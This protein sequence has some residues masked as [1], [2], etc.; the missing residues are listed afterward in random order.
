M[1]LKKIMVLALLPLLIISCWSTDQGP[2]R[3]YTYTVKNESGHDISVR[4]YISYIPNGEPIKTNMLNGEEKTQ[5]Y[6]DFNPPRGYNFQH[7]FGDNNSQRDS[8][9]VIYGDNKI[10]SFKRSGCAG[11]LT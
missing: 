4:S 6:K 2:S 3:T 9:A 11:M 1:R 8:I 10:S 5:V 7:F